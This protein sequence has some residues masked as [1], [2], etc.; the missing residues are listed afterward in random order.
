MS[1]HLQPQATNQ[2]NAGQSLVHDKVQSMSSNHQ[3]VYWF[4]HSAF[5]PHITQAFNWIV[6]LGVNSYTLYVWTSVVF[7]IQLKPAN[8]PRERAA[9]HYITQG[10]KEKIS[11]RQQGALVKKKVNVEKALRSNSRKQSSIQPVKY[12]L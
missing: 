5:P 11:Y 1:S 2:R 4:I 10:N 6:Y 3:A 9:I 12:D 7:K 8:G